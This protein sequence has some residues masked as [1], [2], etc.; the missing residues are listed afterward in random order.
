[1]MRKFKNTDEEINAIAL[2]IAKQVVS[3]GAPGV[4]LPPET[5]ERLIKAVRNLGVEVV[6]D[7]IA[8]ITEKPEYDN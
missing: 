7:S 8:T 6:L 5:D 2:Q 1:M 4:V 3:S